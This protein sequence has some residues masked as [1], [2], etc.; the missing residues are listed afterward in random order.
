VKRRVTLIHETAMAPDN[1]GEAIECWV[2]ARAEKG[3][4][5]IANSGYSG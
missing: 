1:I 5:L 3:M 4:F 2:E